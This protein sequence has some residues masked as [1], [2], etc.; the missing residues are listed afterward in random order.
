M[1]GNGRLGIST[2]SAAAILSDM[3]FVRS[4]RSRRFALGGAGVMMTD[5]GVDW[6][7]LVN[8]IAL[9]S[10]PQSAFYDGVSDPSNPSLYVMADGRSVM[11]LDIPPPPPPQPPGVHV[12][13]AAILHEA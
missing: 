4:N 3:L 1:T 13:L 5:N 8:S 11:R 10:L 2:A 12:E 7:C 9:P 6:Q